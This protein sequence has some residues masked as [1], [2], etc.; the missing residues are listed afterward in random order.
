MNKAARYVKIVE[1]SDE[2]DCFVGSGP[3]MF[4]GGCHG[5]NEKEVFADHCQRVEDVIALYAAEGRD[6]PPV[7]SGRDFATRMQQA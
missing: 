5:D 4:Y 1:W 2:G 6:L 3:G 7:K